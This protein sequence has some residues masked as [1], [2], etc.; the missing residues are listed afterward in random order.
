MTDNRNGKKKE[1][2]TLG[3]L[4]LIGVLAIVLCTVVYR[5]YFAEKST[6]ATAHTSTKSGQ[7]QR[8][9]TSKQANGKHENQTTGANQPEEPLVKSQPWPVYKMA[10][11]IAYDPMATPPMFPR[12]DLEKPSSNTS[13]AISPSEIDKKLAEEVAARKAERQ[14]AITAVQRMEV[15]A[16]LQSNDEFVAMINGREVRV[17]DLLEGLRVVHIDTSGITVENQEIN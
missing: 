3:K 2:V 12:P 11:V 5:N 10:S 15:K 16:V 7:N 6:P 1:E 9:V 8:Q 13:V 4:A 14:R 17:G